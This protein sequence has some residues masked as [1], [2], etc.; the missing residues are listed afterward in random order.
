MTKLLLER[1]QFSRSVYIFG[2][3]QSGKTTLAKQTFPN[4]PY[5]SLEDPD[6]LEFS[7]EDPRGFFSNFS[8]AGGGIIDEPQ[9]N[10]EL[11][12]YLQGQIDN[13]KLKFVLTSS[14]NF[15]T[16]ESIAQS[17]AG[18]ITILNLLPLSKGEISNKQLLKLEQLLTTKDSTM[19]YSNIDYIWDFILHGGYPEVNATPQV[20]P[21]WFS[22]Y[23]K[24]Y[25][26]RDV[27]KIINVHDLTVFQTFIK[28]CA[29]RTGSILNKASLA[30]DCGI[31]ESTC[32]KWL[33][34]LVQSGIIILLRPYYN[35]FKKRQTKSPKLHFIDSGLCC[36]LLGIRTKEH[37]K[38][39]PLM[40][41]ILESYVVMELY[42]QACNSGESFEFY[43]WR[44]QHSN[45][46][47]LIIE[48]PSGTPI[49]IEVKAGQ[50]I[51]SGIINPIKN[52]C[53]MANVEKGIVLYGGTDFQERSE[54]NVI[55]FSKIF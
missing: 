43:Y 29:G 54:V 37:L 32:T 13:E 44:D 35:N 6:I 41:L 23:V 53:K 16:M 1:Y 34:L 11:F 9:R 12:N 42:K 45:E 24:T 15:L 18:R 30:A 20:F 7:R 19:Q 8:E 25:L 5:Y 33:S 49:P 31:S 28:L 47:D 14:Q 3:R 39:H 26:E 10:P 4:L 50:T 17:L 51:S 2:P 40:G 21:H 55:P 38:L 46:I 36:H 22:D 52:W 48:L 27:R